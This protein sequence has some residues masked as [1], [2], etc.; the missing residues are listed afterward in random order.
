MSKSC[1]IFGCYG[2]IKSLP[3]EQENGEKTS[4]TTAEEYG[5]IGCGVHAGSTKL[6][7][8]LPKNQHT[9][10]KLLNFEFWINRELSKSAK[11]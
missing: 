4:P 7:T 6:E 9:Q 1:F 2:K 11:I 10:S 8:F 5:N 3:S